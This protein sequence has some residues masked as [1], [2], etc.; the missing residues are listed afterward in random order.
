M[1]QLPSGSP[2]ANANFHAT[3]E[4]DRQMPRYEWKNPGLRTIKAAGLASLLA[5][6]S[7]GMV[8]A[9][10]VGWV[11]G[12]QPNAT[13]PYTPDPAFSHNSAG[14]AITIVPLGT[15]SYEVEFTGLHSP[16]GMD[17]VQ[18]GG[19]DTSGYCVAGGWSYSGSSVDAR[20]FC[21]DA[22]GNPVNSYFTLLYQ[23]R[24]GTFGSATRG[25]A[26]LFADQPTTAS[27]TPNRVYQYNSTGGANTIVRTG[28][29][30][31][32]ATIP[33]LDAMH[34]DV[35]VTAVGGIALRCKVQGW[36]G[37]ST[38]TRVHVLCFDSSG[39]AADEYY[40]LAYAV[41]D[42]FGSG[43]SATDRG[44]WAWANK[45]NATDSY[46]PN[47]LIQYNGFAT[48]KLTAK[49]TA[50]GKYTVTVPGRISYNT[51][52]SLVTSHGGTNSYC[53][54]TP[55]FPSLILC[56]GQGGVPLDTEF[57]MSL[58]TAD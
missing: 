19:P 15:G 41:N 13:S 9:A 38:S 34:S 51:R 50:T 30:N 43:A 23:E 45:P 36:S 29:G 24:H 33:G 44:S 14:G 1:S 28:T 10:T 35:Q 18:V 22:N 20:A 31:Y 53:N 12:N 47:T 57:D 11:F 54:G 39:V 52:I 16:T 5:F 7:M 37:S 32:T 40:D 27:Y 6:A 58:Q 56:Y 46:T 55:T 26:F 25:L 42:G 4:K 17:D 3:T 8:Q 48:G 49:K 2:F 21:F